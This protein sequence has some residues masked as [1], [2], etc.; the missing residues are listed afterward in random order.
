MDSNLE[1]CKNEGVE[2][3]SP[4]FKDQNIVAGKVAE[5]E[6]EDQDRDLN[7]DYENEVVIEILEEEN[8]ENLNSHRKESEDESNDNLPLSVYQKKSR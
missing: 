8:E 2:D 6:I 4:N 1:D 5:M 3:H 7:E